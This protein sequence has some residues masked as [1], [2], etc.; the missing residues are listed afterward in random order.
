[1]TAIHLDWF[2]DNSHVAFEAAKDAGE[3][4]PA[5]SFAVAA[6]VAKS[7]SRF[8]QVSMT[9]VNVASATNLSDRMVASAFENL[10]KIGFL[11]KR[12]SGHYYLGPIWNLMHFEDNL[13]RFRREIPETYDPERYRPQEKKPARPK[14]VPAPVLTH[15]TSHAE[16]AVDFMEWDHNP[17]DLDKVAALIGTTPT[18]ASLTAWA[19]RLPEGS[20]AWS[21]AFA[22]IERG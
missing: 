12:A 9:Q 15:I 6:V 21:I 17:G 7:A 5:S 22:A 4:F 8:G 20:D 13:Y 3:T 1:M 16:W 10:T 2:V 14:P 11:Q 19:E 18:A